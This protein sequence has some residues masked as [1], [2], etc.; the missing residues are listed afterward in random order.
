LHLELLYILRLNHP[1]EK[2]HLL[3][4][5]YPEIPRSVSDQTVSLPGIKNI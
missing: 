3:M 1:C 4:Q 2:Q 5:K